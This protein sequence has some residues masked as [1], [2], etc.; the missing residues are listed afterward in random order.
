MRYSLNDAQALARGLVIYRA[1]MKVGV[2][3]SMDDLACI[4]A[5]CLALYIGLDNRNGTYSACVKRRKKG[6][7]CHNIYC[8][9][10]CSLYELPP[11]KD[12]SNLE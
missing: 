12:K 11:L 3:M 6:K 8:R 10:K 1:K 2:F 7:P 9:D 4:V 5:I